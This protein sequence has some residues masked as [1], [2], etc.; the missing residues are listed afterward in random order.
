MGW[1]ALIG[2]SKQQAWLSGLAAMVLFLFLS[3]GGV[4]AGRLSPQ[5][6]ADNT[7]VPSRY[8][9]LIQAFWATVAILILYLFT[10]KRRSPMLG[11]FYCALYLCLMFLHPKAQESAYEDWSD[12]LRCVDAV[13]AAFIV[14]APDEQM[15]SVL[16]PL[17]AQRDDIVAFLRR[18][19][20]SVFAEPRA[21]WQGR[22]IPE[23]FPR[24]DK[25]RCIGGV[26]KSLLLENAGAEAAWRVSGWAWD[27]SAD[28]RFEYLLISDSSGLVVGMARGGF[29]HGYFPGFFMETGAV[30][31]YH[32]GRPASEWLGYVRQAVKSPWTVYGVLPRADGICMIEEAR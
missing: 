5:W 2:Q 19:H 22:Y 9:T 15:L 16:W 31:I 23:L 7:P 1:K 25:D 14:G 11:G 8:F 12:A 3:A 18:E 4:V 24:S 21:G 28:R 6:L 29:R 26:E 32:A 10:Y 13:G 20:L 17:K 27:V 30:P